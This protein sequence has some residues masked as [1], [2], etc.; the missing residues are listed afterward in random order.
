MLFIPPGSIFPLTAVGLRCGA[1]TG[2]LDHPFGKKRYEN[3][4]PFVY[5]LQTKAGEGKI[6][7]RHCILLL[8][9]RPS[10]V[11]EKRML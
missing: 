2:Y 6:G 11:K 4:K 9:R 5:R 1:C 3:G 7:S 8:E 10:Y